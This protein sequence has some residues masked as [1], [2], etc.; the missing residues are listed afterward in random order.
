MKNSKS[1]GRANQKDG[2]N[3]PIETDRTVMADQG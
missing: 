3:E 2:A 1:Q